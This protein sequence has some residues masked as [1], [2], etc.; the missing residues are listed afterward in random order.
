MRIAVAGGTGVVG[1]HLVTALGA[2]GH[3]PVVLARS[4]GVDLTT[5]TGLAERLRGVAA[6]V[7][8]SNVTTTRRAVAERFFG[9]AT[10]HLL[11]AGAR[12]GVGHHV[13][14]SIVGVDRVDQGYYQGKRLQ[15]RLVLEGP[16]PASVLRATQFHEFAGQLVGR[17]AGPLALVPRMRVQ[18]VAAREV[19]EA[20][21]G[22]VDGPPV[23]RAPE[24]A[25]PD[26]H[27]LV[28]L[29]RRWLRATGSRRPVVPLRLPGA[30]GRAMAEGAL[31]PTDPG[32]RGRE[33]FDAWLAG[34]AAQVSR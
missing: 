12:A 32:P 34:A 19:A 8:V 27:D 4:A 17:V 23:G 25:G 21:A 31:L 9:G 10:R 7:D 22:L 18:P 15:E 26:V 30:A 6:V 13:V 28:D 33:T 2:A 16:V 24:L 14:L 5:G 3:E 20:L 11:D 29:A 1:R